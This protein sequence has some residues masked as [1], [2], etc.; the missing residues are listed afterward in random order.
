M[1]ISGGERTSAQAQSLHLEVAR[2]PKIGPTASCS[3]AVLA[4]QWRPQPPG[5]SNWGSGRP[6]GARGGR[7]TSRL[8]P[9]ARCRGA[10]ETASPELWGSIATP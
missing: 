3:A 4:P 7:A 9:R 6:G 10:H 2:Q 8:G 1:P 5:G